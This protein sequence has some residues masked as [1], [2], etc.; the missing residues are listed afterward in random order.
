MQTEAKRKFLIDVAFLT[1]IC[2]IIYFIFKF[3][4]VYLLPFVIGIFVSFIVQKP[5]RF[6]SSKTKIPK[7]IT[8]VIFVV[9]TYLFILGIVILIGIGLYSW[10]NS[11][12][13]LIPSLKEPLFSALDT[14]SSYLSNLLKNVPPSL[15]NS[16][17]GIPEKTLNNITGALTSNLPK[18]ALS[19]AEAAPSL[20]ISTIVT[21]VASCYI[22][23]D[24]SNIVKYLYKHSPKNVW[25]IVI[26][27]KEL[28]TKTIF[29]LVRGYLLLMIITFFEL[30][31]GLALIGQNNFIMLAAIICIIDILPVLGTGAVV[32][33]WALISLLT[34]NILKAILLLL[35][36]IVITIVRNFLEPKVIGEQVGLHPLVTL[37]AIFSGYKLIGFWG[38]F[39]FPVTLIILHDLHKNGK[40]QFF[41]TNE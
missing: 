6:I 28:F 26:E 1:V 24:Y 30:A 18:I 37:I 23:G 29:R 11:L 13:K 16:L 38:I 4:S 31:I 20:I 17:S 32:I 27:I 36:Y 35:L 33:P 21:I 14:V 22:A 2:V 39:L 15:I 7:N 34:G 8:T 3:L 25:D 41:K 10:L 12:L 9:F 40:I 5:V 19:V